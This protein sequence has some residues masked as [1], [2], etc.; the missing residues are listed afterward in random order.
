MSDR[1]Q[2]EPQQQPP[3]PAQPAPR[4]LPPD[5]SK[6]EAHKAH[7]DY[8]RGGLKRTLDDP[9]SK[10]F[11]D[12]DLSVL[13]FHGIYQQYDRDER[14]ASRGDGGAEKS[15]REY[16]LMIRARIPG[17]ILT[18]PQY[19]QLDGLSR[20]VAHG[21]IR[22]TTR[23]SIQY[24][25]VVIGDA[26]TLI[27]GMND[28]LISTLAACGDVMRNVMCCPAI[29]AYPARRT[30]QRHADEIALALAPRTTAYHEVWLNGEKLKA[31][32]PIFIDEADRRAKADEFEVEPWYGHVYL[33]RK[34]KVG[35]ALQDDNC[36]DVFTQD[37]GFIAIVDPATRDV[38]AY[39]LLAGGGL[40]MT[41]RKADTFSRLGSFIGA[42]DPKHIID[43]TRIV[44]EIYRD[45]GDREDRRHARLKY[46]IEEFGVEWFRNEFVKRAGFKLHPPIDAGPL[47]YQDH[48]GWTDQG[49]GLFTYGLWVENGR[50]K[51]CDDAQRLSGVRA[52]VETLGCGVRIT[53]AQNLLFTGI[54][55][56]QKN[57][58]IEI[59]KD[60]RVPLVDDI[61][62]LRRHAMA[63]PALPTCGLALG[64]A[65]RSLP[66]LLDD[67]ENLLDEMGLADAEISVRM[68]GCPNGCARPYTPDIGFVGR[69]P[70]VYDVYCGGRLAGD[71]LVDL[72]AEKVNQADILKTLRPALEMFK[73]ER[74]KGESFG[75]FWQR[76]SGRREP[77][78]ILTGAK[79]IYNPTLR[80]EPIG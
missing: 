78:R 67:L 37:C 68:T 28:V 20:R 27:R 72:M 66:G 23:Q 3:A 38:R 2:G 79:D 5:P 50:L 76:K 43:A 69:S 74:F 11:D 26:R 32:D 75:D 17:G 40:G 18:A 61:S 6:V 51:D 1:E 70:G 54:E 41:H 24:H 47:G 35:I 14:A 46:A 63:C 42:I 55:P 33:P 31:D 36:V 16:T 57:R 12:E 77:R 53:P 44:L 52:V 29:D 59:L 56:S 4:R 13:K 71:R 9:A 73:S 19:L 34:F 60:H 45:F 7:S 22:L 80:G 15:E 58:V 64:E 30:V 48:V 10:K 39:N 49:D 62:L 65:E 8:L 21:S 25:G